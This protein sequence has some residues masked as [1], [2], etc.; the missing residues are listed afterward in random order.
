MTYP[1]GSSETFE[2]DAAGTLVRY[3]GLGGR[4]QELLRNARGQLIEAVDPAG[5]RVQYRYD[6][7][8]RLRELQQDHA[9][10]TFTYSAG[11]RLLTETRPDG[12]L[13]RFE[14]GEAGEL[15]GLDIVGA[16]DPM[17]REIVQCAQSGSNVTGWAF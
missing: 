4:V 10:Y 11:G 3:I 13:R 17:R 6:V 12:I 15:L 5:R 2:Y 1:D 14:Y 8:G 9:R 16:P 7:E